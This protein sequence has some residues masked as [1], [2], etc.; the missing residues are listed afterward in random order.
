MMTA[1]ELSR[2]IIRLIKEQKTG[3]E[4]EEFDV[5]PLKLQKLL[6]YCQ[7]YSLALT[8]KP[9][10]PEV[11]E[12]WKYGPVVE[13][14]YQ[15]YKKYTGRIIPLSEGAKSKA[16]DDRLK[17][18]V[19]LVVKEKSQYSGMT[20]AQKV[21]QERPY[22]ESYT[23]DDRRTVISEET[24]KEYFTE[25][26]TEKYQGKEVKIKIIKGKTFSLRGF[27][28]DEY[29]WLFLED[30]LGTL[31]LTMA[32]AKNTEIRAEEFGKLDDGT[33]IIRESGFYYLALFVSQTD[34]AKKFFNWVMHDVMG[35][36]ATKGYYSINDPN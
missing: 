25:Q 35:S 22:L 26:Q 14:V 7:G 36:L 21:K 28:T 34:E 15:E 18:V 16:P 3:I 10:F 9:A 24:L 23:G 30:V 11:I 19:R 12:A 27:E 2:Y 32:D 5:T 33:E 29:L 8:G 1:I 4:P 20:L 6:Y 31:K 13:S 17:E